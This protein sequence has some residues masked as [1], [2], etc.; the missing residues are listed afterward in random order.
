MLLALLFVAVSLFA[1]AL[2]LGW[3]YTCRTTLNK[4]REGR[5]YTLIVGDDPYEE[6]E[7]H[8][9]KEFAKRMAEIYASGEEWLKD[10]KLPANQRKY[11]STCNAVL[12]ECDGCRWLGVALPSGDQGVYCS[13]R[14]LD[15]ME[16]WK[17]DEQG[18]CWKAPV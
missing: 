8:F 13:H 2:R 16:G 5:D 17:W 3:A 18:Q 4:R 9:P 14:C 1:V 11:C 10:R 12:P 15:R 7:L 6:Q